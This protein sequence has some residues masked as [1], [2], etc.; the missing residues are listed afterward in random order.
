MG[1]E[2]LER[3]LRNLRRGRGLLSDDL[4]T[5]V[6]PSLRESCDVSP[7]D[8][9]AVVR[10]KVVGRIGAVARTLPA[11]LQVAVE[12]GLAMHDEAGDR[13][14]YERLRWL[15]GRIER[16][17]RTAARRVEQGLRLL[18]ER[19]GGQRPA[20]MADPVP[21]DSA[22]APG[23][24]YVEALHSTLLLNLELPQLIEERHIVSTVDG[25]GQVMASLTAPRGG[26]PTTGPRAAAEIIYGGEIVHETWP[27]R[28]HYRCTIRLPT[29]LRAG[30]R[31]QYG[32]RFTSY[33]RAD[34]RP[35]YVMTP[36]RRCDRFV[37]RVRFGQG[38]VP[39][40]IQ[41]VDGI[42]RG[43]VDD[44]EPVPEVR[45][46]GVG[47]VQAEFHHLRQGLSYGL[48]WTV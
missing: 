3:E 33:P 10:A 43:I 41:R 47:E 19:M 25:L 20:E 48:C 23:G 32:I 39:S 9:P 42:P 4:A 28:G 1:S 14:L 24:W 8:D 5:R 29:P 34:L 11:D 22:F 13:F 6:G 37:M 45:P 16:D 35:Y 44:L 40:S 30:E 27:L 12:A 17:P 26:R 36:L 18:A 46:D 21:A 31:H 38:M 7:G 15:A 2:Q